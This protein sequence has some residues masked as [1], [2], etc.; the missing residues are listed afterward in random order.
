MSTRVQRL[1]LLDL[2]QSLYPVETPLVNH[3]GERC[4]RPAAVSLRSCR[5]G[6]CNDATAED[7]LGPQVQPGRLWPLYV[8]PVLN[9]HS[10]SSKIPI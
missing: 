6:D 2:L 8:N 3:K 5:G 4:R 1:G 10:G 9:T 7:A